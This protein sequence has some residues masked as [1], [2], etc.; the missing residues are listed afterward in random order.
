VR[1]WTSIIAWKQRLL[2]PT[3]QQPGY[4]GQRE[5]L[6][7]ARTLYATFL[8]APTAV[9]RNFCS[10]E[11]L[12]A[13]KASFTASPSTLSPTLFD[14]VLKSLSSPLYPSLYFFTNLLGHFISYSL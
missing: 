5:A 14:P 6:A 12:N 7:A 3:M 2:N 8:A 13:V 1:L 4:P 11:D 10:Q 9:A